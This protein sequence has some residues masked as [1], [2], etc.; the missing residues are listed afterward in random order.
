M[1]SNGVR[2]TV[3]DAL[4]ADDSLVI[5]TIHASIGETELV[6]EVGD[7]GTLAVDDRVEVTIWSWDRETKLGEA[8]GPNE[9]TAVRNA[10]S[11]AKSRI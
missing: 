10:W 5:T 6:V 8:T 3:H 9:S 1:D 11:K 2:N 7:R 4:A